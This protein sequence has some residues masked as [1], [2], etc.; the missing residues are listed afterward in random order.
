MLP[1]SEIM[2]VLKKEKKQTNMLLRSKNLPA[3]T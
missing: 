2:K 1:L 3:I